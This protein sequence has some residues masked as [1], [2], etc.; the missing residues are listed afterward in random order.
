MALTDIERKI[1]ELLGSSNLLTKSELGIKV[2]Q[3]G[4]NGTAD[5][6]LQRLRQIG[7]VEHVESLGNCFVLTQD[8]I[9]AYE[10]LKKRGF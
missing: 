9:K 2:K 1:L 5:I 3:A 4:F 6:G 8:G 10:D 7:Y